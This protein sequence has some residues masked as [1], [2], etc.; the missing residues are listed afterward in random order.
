MNRIAISAN[1]L[2]ISFFVFIISYLWASYLL[3]GFFI[4][5][6]VAFLV[7]SVI[8]SAWLFFIHR[9]NKIN[10]LTK[11]EIEHMKNVIIQLQFMSQ[12]QSLTLIAQALQ[13]KYSDEIKTNKSNDKITINV[14]QD[15]ISTNE[16]NIFPLFHK[17]LNRQDVIDCINKT[18]DG[19]KS[20]IIGEIPIEV[21]AFFN[22]LQ[23]NVVFISMEDI[24]INLLKQVEIYPAIS[25]IP[26]TKS[27][28]N[29]A[30]FKMLAFSRRKTKSYIIVGII[31][32]LTSLIVRPTLLYIIIATLLF[33]FA[34]ISW[35][36]PQN[37]SSTLFL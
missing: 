32:L 20:I 2:I 26:K 36:R 16:I 33:S 19:K 8:S 11:T 22:S 1:F 14:F 3:S 24:Y 30:T 23:L 6:L 9:K 29:F 21:I 7:T 37:K 15:K 25:I 34:I 17:N 31:I 10:N 13:K 27:R 35:L 28:L 5:F 4:T 12:A 18:E